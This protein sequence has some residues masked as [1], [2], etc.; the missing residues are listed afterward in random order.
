MC[1]VGGLVL[2]PGLLPVVVTVKHEGLS[3]G[4]QG[5]VPHSDE[6]CRQEL[7]VGGKLVTQLVDTVQEQEEQRTQGTFG[8][9]RV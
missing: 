9:F 5:R 2:P 1:G 6:V 7:E 8:R 4:E 3:D